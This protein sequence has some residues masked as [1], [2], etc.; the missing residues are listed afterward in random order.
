MCIKTGKSGQIYFGKGYLKGGK[1]FVFRWVKH[2]IAYAKSSSYTND[3]AED[4][5]FQEKISGNIEDDSINLRAVM[6]NT[7]D[8]LSR[9]IKIGSQTVRLFFCEGMFNLQLMSEL[10][11]EPL[12]KLK[13]ENDTPH[14]IVE[15]MRLSSVL[16]AEQVE[17]YTFSELT[18]FIMSGFAIVLIDGI[19]FGFALGM[20][21]FQFRSIS[22]PSAEVNE[23]GSREGFIE[24]IRINIS[25]I[26]RR[27]KSDKLKFEMMQ[28]GRES[29]TDICLVYRTD[30]VSQKLLNKVRRR[31]S[32]IELDS[33]LDSGYLQ[34]FL[35]D[36]PYSVFSGIGVTERPDTMC[37]KVSEGRIGI[38]VDGT[39]FA[40]IVPFL[41]TEHFQSFDDYAHRSYYATFIRFLKYLS[42]FSTILIPG[43]YVAVASFH[44][45]LFPEVLLFNIA[46]SEESTP[47]PI[48]IEALIIHLIFEIMREAGLRLPRPVGHAVSIVGALVIGDAAVT[49]GLIGA[50]M[51]MVVAVTAISSFVVPSLYEPV[52][53]L[54]IA[55]IIAGGT[56]GTY[57][58]AILLAAVFI[59]LSSINMYGIPITSPVSPVRIYDSRDTFIRAGW[60]TLGKKRLKVQKLPG[61][62][63]DEN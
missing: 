51:V 19:N 10:L 34:P 17:V 39:P 12:M 59:S 44:P 61:A 48:A 56:F 38:L 6:N 27:M 42:F 25:M 43:L 49:A 55:F 50:P 22:E 60:R 4:A 53:I 32:N 52:S 36:N 63:I 11:A 29:R 31:L 37:A 28:V 9:E 57:G 2:R 58:I 30:A 33:V 18:R 15:W 21:G 41:F 26:R 7:N 54:R 3:S 45:E 16:A 23:R 14:E 1:I 40:L 35:E 13:L 24:I 20:Q 47:F 62:E 5:A 46:A 8:L